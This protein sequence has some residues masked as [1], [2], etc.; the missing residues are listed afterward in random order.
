MVQ[1]VTQLV[2]QSSP[3]KAHI[4][5]LLNVRHKKLFRLQAMGSNLSHV[6]DLVV[7]H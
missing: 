6:K 2:S 3:L 1:V 5:N 7:A 4:L